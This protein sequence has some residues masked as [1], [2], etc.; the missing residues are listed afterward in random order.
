MDLTG[1]LGADLGVSGEVWGY[2]T[3][4]RLQL[5]AGAGWE[6]H[7][8]GRPGMAG[9]HRTP[10]SSLR[11]MLQSGSGGCV[12][13]GGTHPCSLGPSARRTRP[14]AAQY[15]RPSL[16]DGALRGQASHLRQP[17]EAR[18]WE[19]RPQGP[20]SG[21][22]SGIHRPVS[23]DHQPSQEQMT[24]QLPAQLCLSTKPL[25]TRPPK[26]PHP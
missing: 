20:R 24:G 8:W 9:A 15:Q 26:Q 2:E 10:T 13:Q 18:L 22:L 3:Q 7:R 17:Q 12:S 6:A 25:A 21:L 5:P 19:A 14:G 23:P 16:G 11:H 1:A 4:K